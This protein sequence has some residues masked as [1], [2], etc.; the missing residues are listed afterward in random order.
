MAT[1]DFWYN[2]DT[3]AID[4]QSIPDWAGGSIAAH[5]GLSWHGPFKTNQAAIDYYNNNKA[6]NPGWKAPTNNPGQQILNVTPGGDA[7]QNAVTGGLG[8]LQGNIETI[9]IRVGEV[10]IGL[11]LLGIGVAMLTHAENFVSKAAKVAA[12]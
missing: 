11:V 5:L 6:H 3:G 12:L 1:G 2:S 10:L 7:V 8:W 4:Q 9:F